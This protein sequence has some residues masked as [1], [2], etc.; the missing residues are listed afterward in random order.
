MAGKTD[1][2]ELYDVE[3]DRTEMNNLARIHP[4]RVS[5]MAAAYDAWA[6]RVGV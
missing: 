3:K 5:E 4:E 2:W 6:K 1:S